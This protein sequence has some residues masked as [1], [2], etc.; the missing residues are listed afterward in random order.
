MHK[1]T[2]DLTSELS[3]LPQELLSLLQKAESFAQNLTATQKRLLEEDQ[4]RPYAQNWS[5]KR[6]SRQRASI[7]SDE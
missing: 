1:N 5:S 2:S 6:K 7:T 4:N 3:K